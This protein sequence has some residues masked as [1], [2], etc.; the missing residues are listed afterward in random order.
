MTCTLGLDNN[1]QQSQLVKLHPSLYRD[2]ACMHRDL[3][4]KTGRL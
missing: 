4:L 3:R 1:C 2:G